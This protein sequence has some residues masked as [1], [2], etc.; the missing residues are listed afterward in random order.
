M[1]LGSL[2]TKF[3]SAEQLTAL[4]LWALRLLE[5]NLDTEKKARLE[6]Y[7]ADL[8]QWEHDSQMMLATVAAKE[9]ELRQLTLQG[10]VLEQSIATRN[11]KIQASKETIR[12]IDE[13]PIKTDMGRPVDGFHDDLRRR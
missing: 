13:E 10:A 2:I 7:R 11:T 5:E 8:K 3:L 6:K 1:A 4:A 9:A 12:S